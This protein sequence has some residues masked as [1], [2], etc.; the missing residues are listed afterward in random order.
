MTKASERSLSDGHAWLEGAVVVLILLLAGYLRL[1]NSAGNP[2]W[3]SDEGTL[4]NIAGHMLHGRVQDFALT[5]STLL[6]ARLP[7]YPLLASLW[8]RIAGPGI[9]ALRLM[10]G[11][12]GVIT[13]G[14][15]YG[16]VRNCLGRAGA[17]LSLAAAFVLAVY[18]SAVIYSRMGFSYNLLAPLALVAFWGA[19]RYLTQG[20]RWALVLAALAV[21]LGC[22][23]DIMMMVF[24]VL[25]G[26]LVSLRRLRDLTWSISLALLPLG[27]YTITLLTSNTKA[28]IFD[29]QFITS[30]LGAVP[31]WAQPGFL[32]LN[33]ATLVRNDV[34][35][36]LAIVGMFILRPAKWRQLVGLTFFFPIIAVGRST[37]LA[38]LRSYYVI[39]LFPFVAMGVAS[40]LVYGTPIVQRTLGEA[41]SQAFDRWGWP[42]TSS[43]SAWVRRRAIALGTALGVFL[44][45]LTP[46]VVS[47]VQS[48]AEV[49]SGFQTSAD[50]LS[51]N[52]W[53]AR[54]VSQFVNDRAVPGELVIA[55]PA[56]G[57][58]LDGNVAELEQVI[59]ATGGQTVDYPNNVP[60]DRFAYS[61]RYQ[62]AAY[63]VVD[64]VWDNWAAVFMPDVRAMQDEI[65]KW[66]LALRLGE[67]RVYENPS[68]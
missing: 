13:C 27:I 22:V 8:F 55:S 9:P 67:F 34:W 1:A 40:L 4:V 64:R 57:W 50:D 28:F 51:I 6:A 29:V 37:G 63:V 17:V 42:E 45:A 52:P 20:D 2:G 68:R 58:L 23:T 53:D 48:V 16:V 30:R 56:F 15:V 19:W 32:S 21:G 7:L 39:P 10:S 41:F 24:L 12:L 54:E 66:P 59:A 61:M 3:Y 26:L 47:I 25:L 60:A 43:A 38:G 46:V 14:L 49:Q 65:E 5:G 36:A 31:L 11:S 35:I 62:D 18:P 44:I 33:L